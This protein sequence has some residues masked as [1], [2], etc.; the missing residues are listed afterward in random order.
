MIEKRVNCWKVDSEFALLATKLELAI[1]FMTISP[2]ITIMCSFSLLV[3]KIIFLKLTNKYNY[4]ITDWHYNKFPVDFLFV[5]LCFQQLVLSS[6]FY[7]N[8]NDWVFF[9]MV[10]CFILMDMIYIMLGW[11]IKKT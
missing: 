8:F 7:T 11:R 4:S 5:S 1:M 2:Y 9:I 10:T 3:N 6:F